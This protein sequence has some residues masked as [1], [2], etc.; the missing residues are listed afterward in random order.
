L[1]GG[2]GAGEST[3]FVASLISSGAGSGV[4]SSAARLLFSSAA[5]SLGGAFGAAILWSSLLLVLDSTVASEGHARFGSE[6]L[7]GGRAMLAGLP[8]DTRAILIPALV[9]AFAIAFVLGAAIAAAAFAATFFLKEIPLRS[10][11][12]QAKPQGQ[13]AE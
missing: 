7:R 4:I 12:H 3:S 5:S 1:R 6:L 11:T 2:S 10:T 9:H 8:P 13:G